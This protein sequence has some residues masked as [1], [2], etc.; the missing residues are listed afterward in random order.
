LGVDWRGQI[1]ALKRDGYQG[2]ISL[3]THWPG[4]AGNKHL[5]STICGWNLKSLVTF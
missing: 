3:E 4:P 5:A 2:W 1:A